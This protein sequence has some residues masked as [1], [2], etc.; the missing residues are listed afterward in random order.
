MMDYLIY[1]Y[2][3]VGLLLFIFGVKAYWKNRG[4]Y[5]AVGIMFIA[6]PQLLEIMQSVLLG[7]FDFNLFD[8]KYTKPINMLHQ[9]GLFIGEC[10]ILFHFLIEK[11]RRKD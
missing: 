2:Y 8:S 5:L 10:M 6:F 9:S 3:L 1:P 11:N 7:Y 4:R